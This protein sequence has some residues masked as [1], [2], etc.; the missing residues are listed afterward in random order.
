MNN[1]RGLLILGI[2][3]LAGIGL[4]AVALLRSGSGSEL[5]M[6]RAQSEVRP[7]ESAG[8]A[9]TIPPAAPR[10]SR[11][12]AS[13][14][15]IAKATDE[16]R[17]RVTYQNFRTAVATGNRA[18]LDELR[19][20]ILRDRDFAIQLANKEMATAPSAVD[21]EIAGRTLEALRR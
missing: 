4:L 12:P 6:R 16:A 15:K 2:P 8:S 21:R 20:I 14:E 1:R 11:T 3:V 5:P 9:P 10:V 7:T 13:E 18:L 17:V 19:P